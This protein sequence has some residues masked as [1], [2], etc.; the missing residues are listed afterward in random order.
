MFGYSRG[1]L[2]ACMHTMTHKHVGFV[3][4]E[5]EAGRKKWLPVAAHCHSPTT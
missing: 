1:T 5:E 2:G 3:T 4:A